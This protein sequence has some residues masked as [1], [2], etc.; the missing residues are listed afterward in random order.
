MPPRPRD[1]Q[2]FIILLRELPD[3]PPTRDRA[4]VV[5]ANAQRAARFLE[6]L[7]TWLEREHLAPQVSALGEPMAVPMLA[8][9]CTPEVA[10]RIDELP[11]VEGVLRDT[12]DIRLAR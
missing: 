12:D 1:H 2:N 7:G 10:R 11:D 6:S 4:S 3:D 5:R 9:T 8:I